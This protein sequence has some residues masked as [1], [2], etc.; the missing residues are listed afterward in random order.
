MS[1]NADNKVNLLAISVQALQNDPRTEKQVMG[2]ENP[3]NTFVIF[4][5]TDKRAEHKEVM[6]KAGLT[7]NVTFNIS[8]P[9]TQHAYAELNTV[10]NSSYLDKRY[11]N[12][13]IAIVGAVDEL[14]TRYQEKYKQPSTSVDETTKTEMKTSTLAAGTS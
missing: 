14:K 8:I 3:E 6:N 4:S 7:S 5:G 10:S 13:N 9:G 2:Y 1:D 11:P 12:A